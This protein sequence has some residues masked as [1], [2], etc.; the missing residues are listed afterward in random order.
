[1]STKT[2]LLSCML[3]VVGGCHYTFEAAETGLVEPLNDRVVKR[4]IFI[5]EIL[6]EHSVDVGGMLFQTRTLLLDRLMAGM[7]P[8]D[9]EGE[10]PSTGW[11]S[12]WTYMGSDA[13]GTRI[14]T[15]PDFYDGEI[16]VIIDDYGK[17]QTKEPIIQ[18]VGA[19]KGRRWTT[20]GGPSFF[21]TKVWGLRYGG[22]RGNAHRMMIVD[23]PG[24]RESEIIQ[25]FEITLDEAAHGFSVK[26]VRV[27]ILQ[28]D[29]GRILY[30]F[31]DDSTA[32]SLK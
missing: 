25:D 24:D 27:Q 12:S 16:G 32:S 4:T 6:Q 13:Q 8:V 21:V 19:K 11:V 5:P 9:L 3:I 28:Y 10:F 20:T 17:T 18:L 23:S 30:R 31:S 26:G 7:R 14:Y 22:V 1:M 29:A 2:L 15:N